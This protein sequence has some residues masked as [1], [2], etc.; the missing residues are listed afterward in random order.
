DLQRA[1]TWGFNR[2]GAY[3]PTE[4]SPLLT[5]GAA[6]PSTVEPASGPTVSTLNGGYELVAW[7]RHSGRSAF[8]DWN[9]AEPRL[10]ISYQFGKH[11][12]IRTGYGIFYLPVDV[13][14]NDAPH[15]LFINSFSTPWQ[16][17]QSDGV[18]PLNPL[19]NPEPLG[20]IPPFGRNQ[21]LID[22]QGNG[23]EAALPNNPAPYAQ[24]WN[25]DIQ[26]QLPGNTL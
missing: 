7:S 24:Q 25:F 19:S 20:I 18:T 23:N 16:T 17:A 21:A 9:H 11:T 10:G 4:A 1:W 13:R 26:R 5:I 14:W 15:N 6:L 2:R 12:V 8:P 22:V 3:N